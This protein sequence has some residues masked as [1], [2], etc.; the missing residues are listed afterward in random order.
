VR[1][2]HCLLAVIPF[3]QKLDQGNSSGK[4]DDSLGY[5]CVA[6]QMRIPWLPVHSTRWAYTH[7]IMAVNSNTQ[8]MARVILHGVKSSH[9]VLCLPSSIVFMSGKV[10]SFH[11]RPTSG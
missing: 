11:I 2:S 8:A 1:C 4:S 5:L 7:I 10:A 3:Q 6:L 9:M